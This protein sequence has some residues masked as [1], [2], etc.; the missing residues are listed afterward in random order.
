MV[1][2]VLF[3]A[4]CAFCFSCVNLSGCASQELSHT[5]TMRSSLFAYGR[6]HIYIPPGEE[7]AE[8]DDVRI[9]KWDVIKNLR[10]VESR[11]S[12]A[13]KFFIWGDEGILLLYEPT[14]W[15]AEGIGEFIDW[16]FG[17]SH[18]DGS[19]PRPASFEEAMARPK[20]C[21]YLIILV[22]TLN[23]NVAYMVSETL[24]ADAPVISAYAQRFSR[25]MVERKKEF[26]KNPPP[27]HES[28]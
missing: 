27:P 25:M 1:R 2:N 3:I 11:L 26:I 9:E 6:K 22:N 21:R 18:G 15:A 10:G 7:N 23:P 20:G 24:D 28:W 14:G 4:V 17:F 5:F 19:Q 12:P 13:R 8:V 16:N